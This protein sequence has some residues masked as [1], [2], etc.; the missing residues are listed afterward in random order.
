MESFMLRTISLTLLCA[1]TSLCTPAYSMMTHSLQKGITLEYDFPPR[2]P[3]VFINYMFWPIEANC[4]I[5]SEATSV[6]LFAEALVKK[7]KIN[8]V[9]LSAGQNIQL[10]VHS[11]ESIKLNADS[12]AKVQITNLSDHPVHATCVS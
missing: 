4:K 7:G 12:G 3:Q 6:D 11:G 2:D 8:D 9:T 10:S 5:T 1:A